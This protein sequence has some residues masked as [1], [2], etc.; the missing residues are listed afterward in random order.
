MLVSMYIIIGETITLYS[1]QQRLDQGLAI[2]RG[3][4]VPLKSGKVRQ[5]EPCPDQRSTG[6]A[7]SFHQRQP[8]SNSMIG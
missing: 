7:S 6:K 2:L 3:A 5:P 1:L 4:E 8:P